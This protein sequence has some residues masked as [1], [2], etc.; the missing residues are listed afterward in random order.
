MKP[1]VPN[2]LNKDLKLDYNIFSEELSEAQYA[3]GLLEGSQKKLHNSDLLVSPLTAKEAT[4]SSKIEGTQST[5][6]DVFMFEAGGKTKHSDIKQVTNYRMAISYAIN[7]LRSGRPITPYL[8]KS[9]HQLLLTDVRHNG[10]LGEFR[11]GQVWIAERAG[12]GIEKARYVPP[13]H[14]LI[15]EYIDDL[16][17]FIQ[18]SPEKALI[19]AGIV[20]Y[21]FEAV[22]PFDDGNGRIGRLLIPLILFSEQ[23]ISSPILYISGYF[24]EHRDQ[25]MDELR[26]VDRTNSFESWLKFFLHST[27]Q[28]LKATQRIIEEI[29]MLH[30]VI[31]NKFTKTKS[32]YIFNFIDFIFKMPVF[33]ISQAIE[34]LGGTRL[35]VSQLIKKFQQ[36]GLLYEVIGPNKKTKLYAFKP[37]IDI[38]K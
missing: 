2:K 26:N 27:A 22:H 3:L 31:K 38:I 14:I 17:E 29:Y 34:N 19:K 24:E 6:S 10:T 15:P 11:K 7:E 25:Y 13:E 20:H 18:N 30:D 4:V 35:T 16:F 23:V 36:E 5:V 32:P 1:R 28:Q 9:L 21:Q 37:L 33:S 8:V 12:E